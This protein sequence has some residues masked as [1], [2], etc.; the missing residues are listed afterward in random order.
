M[1]VRATQPVLQVFDQ[2][3]RANDKPKAEV[4]IDVEI[5]EVDRQRVKQLGLN[6]SQ[7][8]L[9]FSMS[10]EVAPPNTATTPNA[11]P[12]QPPPFNLNTVSQ[13]VSTADFYATIPTALIRLLESD[14]TTKLL[15]R[16]QLRGQERASLTL[17]LG[18][19]IP[20]PTTTFAAQAT[21]GIANQPVTSFRNRMKTAAADAILWPAAKRR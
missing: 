11:F 20:I 13:G 12:Q 1:T 4:L 8:A 3:I 10:P 14:T 7:Y 5:L 17:N 21:G 9:G 15:A 2:L 18:D 16:P 6:L 19:E